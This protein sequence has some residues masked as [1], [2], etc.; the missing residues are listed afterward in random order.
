MSQ[1]QMRHVTHA[2][3]RA[4]LMGGNRSF[5]LSFFVDVFQGAALHICAKCCNTSLLSQGLLP[6][7]GNTLQPLFACYPQKNIKPEKDSTMRGQKS[8]TEHKMCEEP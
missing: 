4:H 8:K 7:H 3:D 5:Q 1:E 2:A 6:T